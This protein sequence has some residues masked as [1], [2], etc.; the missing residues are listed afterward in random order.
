[1]AKLVHGKDII[2]QIGDLSMREKVDVG[3]ICA[4]GALMEANLA[5]YDRSSHEYRKTSIDEPAEL[6]SCSGNVSI[7]DGVP[8]VH[9]HAV[10]ANS[11]GYARAGHLI[12]GNV[13]A[14]ELCLHELLGATLERVYD[15]IMV[16]TSGISREDI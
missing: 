4:I 10:L 15:K 16:S 1:M 7:R 3:T 13:F 12:R 9:A 8:F 14:A 5:Y 6:V 2:G 11:K